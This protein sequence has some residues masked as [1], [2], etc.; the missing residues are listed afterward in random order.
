MKSTRTSEFHNS[1]PSSIRFAQLIQNLALAIFLC[2]CL[3]VR[4]QELG[5]R[6]T[7]PGGGFSIQLP[8]GW[9]VTKND[10]TAALIGEPRKHD[11]KV[12]AREIFSTGLLADV[13]SQVMEDS[14]KRYS[15]FK[16]FQTDTFQ[17]NSGMKGT[18]V[19]VELRGEKTG[20]PLTRQILF[21][22]DGRPGYKVFVVC[23]ALA[24]GVNKTVQNLFEEVINSLRLEQ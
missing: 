24:T 5:D 14:S 4:A 22:F 13:V 18:E 19:F 8:N 15:D 3:C 7:A 16:V 2:C 12:I 23:S 17:T 20:D 10:Q 21:F 11:M 1:F 6:Q 9:T